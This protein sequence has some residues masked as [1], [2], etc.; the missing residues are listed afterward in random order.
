[1]F[2]QKQKRKK[3][4]NT[5]HEKIG[6]G[7]PKQVHAHYSFVRETLKINTFTKALL[8]FQ[9]ASID[10]INGGFPDFGGSILHGFWVSNFEFSSTPIPL[11]RTF[12]GHILDE[13][14]T[15]CSTVSRERTKSAEVFAIWHDMRAQQMMSNLIRHELFSTN[16]CMAHSTNAHMC[17]VQRSTK[18]SRIL[19]CWTFFSWPTSCI[20][21]NT[22]HENVLFLVL[23]RVCGWRLSE[24][25][26][27]RAIVESLCATVM[28]KPQTRPEFY[29][30]H[31]R[32]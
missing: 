11:A 10:E 29:P 15:T 20:W 24:T 2:R 32:A 23:T 5:E 6:A 1:M 7:L 19:S 21:R 22:E 12:R 9:C 4:K 26:R 30:C 17:H 3:H 14:I 13:K 16:I 27:N 18:S 25:L 31:S 8:W 28:I